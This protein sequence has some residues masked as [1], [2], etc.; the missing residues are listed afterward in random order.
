[1]HH[2]LV[3]NFMMWQ[4]TVQTQMQIICMN[5][6]DKTFTTVLQKVTGRVT[7]LE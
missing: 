5:S 1:M 2:L 6:A 4:P 7:T 3:G